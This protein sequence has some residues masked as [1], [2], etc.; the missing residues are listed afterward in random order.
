MDKF[1]IIGTEMRILLPC[2]YSIL[3]YMYVSPES[4]ILAKNIFYH[5]SVNFIYLVHFGLFIGFLFFCLFVH[6]R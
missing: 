4:T 1:Y 2:E 5:K 3:F 6:I